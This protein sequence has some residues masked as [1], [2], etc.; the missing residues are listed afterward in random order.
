[1]KAANL[2]VDDT[3]TTTV[4]PLGQFVDRLAGKTAG[5]KRDDET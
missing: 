4:E 1:M 3:V 5:R 2:S